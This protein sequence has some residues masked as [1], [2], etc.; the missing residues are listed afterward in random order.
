MVLKSLGHFG[1][2][3]FSS[4]MS[5][6]FCRRHELFHI[7]VQLLVSVFIFFMDGAYVLHMGAA[8]IFTS[9][10]VTCG[11]I[12]LH[13]FSVCIILFLLLAFFLCVCVK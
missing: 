5:I 3:L 8:D 1:Q 2:K 10:R 11:N 6:Q 12:S 7:I 4:N 9:P 13:V